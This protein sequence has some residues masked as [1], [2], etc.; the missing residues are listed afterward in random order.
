MTKLTRRNPVVKLRKM[1][2]NQPPAINVLKAFDV[3]T[4]KHDIA[5]SFYYFV[6]FKCPTHTHEAVYTLDENKTS[7]AANV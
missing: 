3:V 6:R 1:F 5:V 7:K 2:A 4:D